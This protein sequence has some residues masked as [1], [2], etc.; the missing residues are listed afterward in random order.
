[1]HAGLFEGFLKT[2]LTTTTISILAIGTAGGARGDIIKDMQHR[3]ADRIAIY[4]KP[5]CG[6]KGGNEFLMQRING[7][8]KLSAHDIADTYMRL[9]RLPVSPPAVE[10][11]WPF[12]H[13]HNGDVE[14]AAQAYVDNLD[15]AEKS[16]WDDEN[17]RYLVT[18]LRESVES[19]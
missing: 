7:R 4:H 2:F 16:K 17:R 9:F 1:M 11:A 18:W 12:V 15:P 19:H 3:M 10:R 5:Q 14:K 13:R 6:K 8:V